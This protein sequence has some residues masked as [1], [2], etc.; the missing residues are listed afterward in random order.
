MRAAAGLLLVICGAVGDGESL[1]RAA[2][3]ETIAKL[4]ENL[5]AAR[6]YKVRI[7]AAYLIARTRDPR[8]L[9]LLARAASSDPEPLV[10]SFALRLLGKN[11]GRDPEATVARA[12]CLKARSDP[13]GVVR[14]QAQSS[15]ADLNRMKAMMRPAAAAPAPGASGPRTRPMAIAVGRM[16]DR[17]GQ[18]SAEF[19]AFMRSEI[20]GQLQKEPNIRVADPSESDLT[21]VVDGTIRRLELATGA[22]GVESTCAIELII[23]RPTRGLV[24]VAS[25]EAIVQKPRVQYRA[26]HRAHMESEALTHAVQSAHENLSKFLATQ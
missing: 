21:F 6:S 22:D 14:K 4:S 12:A 19:R 2:S 17:T 23:S 20:I 16:A 7:H 24:L 3:S 25:G 1:A 15:L 13:A 8:A 18:A 11:P 5:A 26:H 9:E 10:R